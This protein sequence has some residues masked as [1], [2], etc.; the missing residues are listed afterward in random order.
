MAAFLLGRKNQWRSGL[1]VVD[2]YAIIFIDV[3]VAQWIEHLSP[4]QGAQVRFLSGTLNNIRRM[5]NSEDLNES[6]K[7]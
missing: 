1:K 4:E 6:S 2:E 5:Q 7:K 3:P